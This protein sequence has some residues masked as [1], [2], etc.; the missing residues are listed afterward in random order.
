[1][2]FIKRIR[3]FIPATVPASLL[4]CAGVAC[5]ASCPIPEQIKNAQNNTL[6]KAIKALYAGASA[7]G[8]ECG[9]VDSVVVK[10]TEGGRQGGRK[11][12]PDGKFDAAAA[13]QEW[14][15]ASHAPDIAARL[16]ALRAST[17]DQT[18]LK[19]YQAAVMDEEGAY[20]A[21]DWLLLSLSDASGS[22]N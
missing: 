14:E 1:M 15:T 18:E 13:R 12:E 11:L 10:L 3:L 19:L 17:N 6:G 21:R 2:T 22:N 5:A 4:L 16:A 7:K 20:L 9:A 8:V